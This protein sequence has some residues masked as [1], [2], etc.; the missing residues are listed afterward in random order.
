MF[1]ADMHL[2]QMTKLAKEA[3]GGWDLGLKP[4]CL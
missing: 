4:A 1:T 2:E 3:D